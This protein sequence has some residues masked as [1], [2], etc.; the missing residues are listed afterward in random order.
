MS[1]IGFIVDLHYGSSFHLG[2]ID[3]STQLN[4]RLLDFVKTYDFIIDYFE[5]EKVN[6][7]VITGDIFDVRTPSPS[8]MSAF[9]KS[10]KKTIDKGFE[11]ILIAGNHDQQRTIDTTTIDFINNLS[12]DKVSVF[13]KIG[14]KSFNDFH[15]VLMPYVD[16]KMLQADSNESASNMI[17]KQINDL[18]SNLNGP[19]ILVGHSMLESATLKY[20]SENF[21]LKEIVFP[22]NTFSKFDAVIMGHMHIPELIKN[23]NPT[24]L[25]VGSMEKITFGDRNQPKRVIIMDSNDVENFQSIDTPV[26]NIFEINFDY[27]MHAPFKN[28]IT[29]KIISDLNDYE[30]TNDIKNSIVRLIVKMSDVDIYYLN[31]ERI[32]AKIL[33]SKVDS[34]VSMQF[35][36]TSSRQLRDDTIN[37]KQNSKKAFSSFVRNLKETENMKKKILK[38]GEQI[39]EE[40]DGK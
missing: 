15:L 40:V 32:K 24:T 4:S 3:P 20:D 35:V 25:Y 2:H 23:K 10:L 36:S 31:Q 9:S 5:K 37:E 26:R 11:I 38:F 14:I 30:K 12:L 13:S 17:K 21:S 29:D 19:K 27:S 39:I 22:I 8:V 28:T 16:R 1:K 6:I 34:L 18:I 7:I 33:E